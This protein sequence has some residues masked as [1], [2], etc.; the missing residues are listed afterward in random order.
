MGKTKVSSR[1]A[2]T[3]ERKRLVRQPLF[4]WLWSVQGDF[5]CEDLRVG[6][7]VSSQES[8]LDSGPDLVGLKKVTQHVSIEFKT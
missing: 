5:D 7:P 4:C 6:V 8:G 3:K 1:P 2:A